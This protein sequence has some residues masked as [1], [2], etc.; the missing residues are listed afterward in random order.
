M[1]PARESF[2]LAS[3]ARSAM[4]RRTK[5]VEL[6]HDEEDKS[7]PASERLVLETSPRFVV[8]LLK[9]ET[10]PFHLLSVPTHQ[11]HALN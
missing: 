2:S 10:L 6:G 3:S 9:Q 1:H 7:G 4:M 8:V 5:L 11:R